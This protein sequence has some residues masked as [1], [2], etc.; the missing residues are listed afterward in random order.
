VSQVAR[1]GEGA[2]GLTLRASEYGKVIF[3][4]NHRV[5]YMFGADHSTTS[6]CYGVCATA[7]PPLLA[8]GTPSV[9]AGLNAKLLGTTKRNDGS[10]Q[11]I[12]RGHPLYYYSG[13]MAGKIMCQAANMHG[14]FWYVVNA[15]GSANK[16]KGH[17]MMMKEHGK[18]K[19]HTKM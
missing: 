8:K 13:D 10:L 3:D 6:T 2:S 9:A 12:Y 1:S 14:G 11:V 19:E 18:M 17:G 16:A 5:L 7:W 4:A 15:D